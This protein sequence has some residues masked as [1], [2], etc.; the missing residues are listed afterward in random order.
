[1]SN[2]WI[3]IL[4]AIPLAWGLIRGFMRG[5][6]FELAMLAAITIASMGSFY[7]AKKVSVMLAETIPMTGNWLAI[8]SHVLVFGIIFVLIWFLG[9]A[10]TNIVSSVGLGFINRLLG[11]IFGLCKWMILVSILVFLIQRFD[12]GFKILSRDKRDASWLYKPIAAVSESL[13]SLVIKE[14]ITRY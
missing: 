13:Y 14:K 4:L 1:M 7:L 11:G 8:L 2:H 5:L 12:P 3:D 9:K 6:V 10:L